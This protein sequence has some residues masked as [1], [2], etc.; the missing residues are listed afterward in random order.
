MAPVTPETKELL[1]QEFVDAAKEMVRAQRHA[2]IAIAHLIKVQALARKLKV[3]L[4]EWIV[5]HLRKGLA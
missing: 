5:D 1:L 2:D 3:T 4:P